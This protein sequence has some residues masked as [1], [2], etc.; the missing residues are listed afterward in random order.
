MELCFHLQLFVSWQ[1]YAKT[2]RQ[3]TRKLDGRMQYGLRKNQLSFGVNPEI[4]CVFLK[5]NH[6]LSLNMLY[7]SVSDCC[8]HVKRAAVPGSVCLCE[9]ELWDRGREVLTFS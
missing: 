6:H 7:V 4:I 5:Q 9:C 2:T 3:C 8:K 1:D